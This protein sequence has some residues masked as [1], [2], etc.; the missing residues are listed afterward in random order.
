MKIRTQI[1]DDVVIVRVSGNIVIGEGDVM[2][3][4]RIVS[5]LEDEYRKI[6]LDLAEVKYMDSSGIGELVNC[7]TTVKKRGGE[8]KLLNLTKKIREI[9]TITKLLMVFD[10]YVN[11]EEAI[12]S[13]AKPQET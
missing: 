9:L 5:I 8:M 10:H 2:L 1:A 6:I 13:F 12:Q 7:H 4:D 3:K 11:E